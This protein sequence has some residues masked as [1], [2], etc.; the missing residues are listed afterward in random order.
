M[1]E[2]TFLGRTG[3][4]VP[5]LCF[6]AL[7]ISPLQ[8][9][10]PVSEGARLLC[11]AAQKYGIDFVDTAELYQTYPYIRE[12]L[13]ETPLTVCTKSYAYDAK[14]AEDSFRQAVEGIGREY[15]D[16]FML[17]EQ[18]SEHTLRGHAEALAYFR[19]K[20]EEG[21]I[22]AVGV[23]THFVQVVRRLC[24]TGEADVVFPLINVDGIGIQDGSRQDMEEAIAESARLGM[25]VMAM[26]ALGGG[27]LIGRREEALK[28]ALQLPGVHSVAVGMQS[29]EEIACNVAIAEGRAFDPQL[30]AKKKRT[31]MVHDWCLGCGN[32][33]KR[34]KQGALFL[35]NG[36]AKVDM[37]KCVLCG[38]CGSACKEMCLKVV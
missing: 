12:A 30:A 36:K 27:H 14:T 6:G 18:E 16:I 31:L 22:G 37:E 21:L 23:S 7:T 13:R 9:A 2:R 26:K 5:R 20:K 11:L 29:E 19:K 4:S 8:C 35:E 33:V 28:Y 25:G 32:C 1:L 17:H 24:K 15:I 38:Y 3:I 10:L 34:C